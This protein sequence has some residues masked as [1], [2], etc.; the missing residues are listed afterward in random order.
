MNNVAVVGSWWRWLVVGIV[1]WLIAC[2]LARCEVPR[3]TTPSVVADGDGVLAAWEQPGD[4]GYTIYT[5]RLDSIRNGTTTLR[6]GTAIYHR[7]YGTTGYHVPELAVGPSGAIAVITPSSGTQIAIPLDK[8]GKV[9]GP[10]QPLTGCERWSDF[11][12]FWTC[13]RPVARGDG[14]VAGHVSAYL[15]GGVHGLELSFL[16]RLG[17]TEHHLVI[18]SEYP[19]NCVM[20]SRDDDLLV[21]STEQRMN[22]EYAIHVQFLA[23]ADGSPRTSYW[24]SGSAARSV[25]A[26]GPRQFAL[27]HRDADQREVVS[28]LE[29]D[30]VVGT[31]CPIYD[32]DLQT[33]TLAS[34]T[35]GPFMTWLA[36]G[37]VHI[38]ALTHE[39]DREA[40]RA[41]RT[42]VGVRATGIG[43]R[44]ITAWTSDAGSKLHVRAVPRCP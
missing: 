36:D 34:T 11:S 29:P 18:P 41:G 35:S 40:S 9:I 4:D 13:A 10:A 5:R 32:V 39:T 8:T 3:T 16:D 28:T 20:A 26:T 17:R 14:F 23:L 21:V 27:L 19:L 15:R 12:C 2:F 6:G 44:C 38:R 37:R 22:G 30:G 7:K 43:D 1:G 25:I 33:A 31:K 42:A 24:I